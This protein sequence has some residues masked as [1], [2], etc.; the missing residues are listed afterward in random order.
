MKRLIPFDVYSYKIELNCRYCTRYKENL[1]FISIRSNFSLKM[2][3]FTNDDPHEIQM[4]SGFED[5]SEIN[6]D[7]FYSS[8]MDSNESGDELVQKEQFVNWHWNKTDFESH[9]FHFGEQISGVSSNIS[10]KKNDT[11]LDFFDLLF[12]ETMI[13][14][15]VEQTNKYHDFSTNDATHNTALHQA[16]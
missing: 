14:I 15:I 8:D 10:T 5:D 7:E 16:R 13:D 3:T 6:I 12:D 9:L 4:N 2:A 1:L 11:P